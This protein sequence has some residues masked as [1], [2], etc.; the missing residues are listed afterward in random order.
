MIIKRVFGLTIALINDFYDS[1]ITN[2]GL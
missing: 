2:H 1:L